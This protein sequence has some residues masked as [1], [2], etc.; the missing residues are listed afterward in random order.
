MRR[1]TVQSSALLKFITDKQVLT[2]TALLAFAI[3][4]GQ[5]AE[6]ESLGLATAG[7][8]KGD[9]NYGGV[10]DVIDE[11]DL[12]IFLEAKQPEPKLP[13]GTQLCCVDLNGNGSF[14]EQDYEKFFNEIF[15]AENS[16]KA[17]QELYTRC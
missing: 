2:V 8:L 12:D 9:T 3:I 16:V 11:K 5:F 13:A 7:C 6:P 15:M 4:I 17:S 1:K 14:D 10:A